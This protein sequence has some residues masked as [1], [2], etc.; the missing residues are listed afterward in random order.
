VSSK[1]VEWR[2]LQFRIKEVMLGFLR[3]LIRRYAAQFVA[4]CSC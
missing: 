4:S 2:F 1:V 3:F